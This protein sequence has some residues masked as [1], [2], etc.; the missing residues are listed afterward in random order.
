MQPTFLLI[1][2]GRVSTHFGRYFR[3]LG[4][5]FQ[6]WSRKE[7]LSTLAKRAEA[8]SHILCLISDPAIE[9]FLSSNGLLFSNQILVHASGSLVTPLA[10]GA[11]PLMTFV[12]TQPYDM[13]TYTLETYTSI[14]FVLEKG[15]PGFENLLP[16][17]PN[18]HFEIDPRLKPLYHALCV[19]SGNFTVLLWQKVFSEFEN[20]LGLPREALFPYLQ[21]VTQNLRVDAEQALT[22]PLAR[23]DHKAIAGHLRALGADPFAEVYRAFVK[24]VESR[25]DLSESLS[26]HTGGPK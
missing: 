21:R 24:T 25:P 1:G 3:L 19:M 18:P 20:T 16:G 10:H 22:G 2:D 11:H 14:P 13:E 23:G 6:S 5:R 8:S 17:L 7:D 12:D 15:G 4:L 9:P 26:P